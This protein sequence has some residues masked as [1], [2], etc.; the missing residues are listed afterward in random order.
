MGVGIRDLKNHLSRH[1]A[2]VRAGK[3]ITITDHGQPVARLVPLEGDSVFEQLV[4][5][6]RITPAAGPKRPSTAP[7][8]IGSAV[9]DLLPDQRG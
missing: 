4:A 3:S 8:D 6:G 7:L 5:E 1:L 2:E 9:S